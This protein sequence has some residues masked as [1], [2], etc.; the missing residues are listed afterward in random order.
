MK[1]LLCASTDTPEIIS[2]GKVPLANAFLDSPDSREELFDLTLVF[3]PVCSLVQITQ[4]ID[5]NKLFRNYSY[6]SSMSDTMLKHASDLVD[7]LVKERKLNSLSQVIEI[8]SNDAYLLSNFQKY[9]IPALGIDPSVNLAVIAHSKGVQTITDFF[10][11]RLADSLPKADVII[12]LNV[13]GHVPDPNDF[14]RGIHKVLKPNGVCVIEVPSVRATIEGNSFDQIYHE[15][16]SYWSLSS[17]RYAFKGNNLMIARAEKISIHGGGYRLYVTQ[18]SAIRDRQTNQMFEIESALG[19][20]KFVYYQ[21]FADRVKDVGILLRT[22]LA[23]LHSVG[24][25]IVAYGAAAKGTQLLNYIGA[26]PDIIEY[27]IDSTPVK[28][29]KYVPGCRIPIVSPNN[30]GTQG[31]V[32]LTAHNWRDEIKSKHKDFTGQWIIPLPFPTIE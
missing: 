31:Y 2:F 24:A 21:C 13:L 17:L 32:L 27:V 25:R 29:G 30:L 10:S 26:T 14:L 28:I 9:G 7:S 1:C 20:D 15:H 5:P 22:L 4:S 18:P 23:G 19:L 16:L 11:D 12:A 3:C 8:A 6:Y